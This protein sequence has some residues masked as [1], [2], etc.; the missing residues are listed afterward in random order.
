MNPMGQ[1]DHGLTQSIDLISAR[2]SPVVETGARGYC[3][4]HLTGV[5]CPRRPL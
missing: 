2:M 5:G 1:F 3:Q 4:V